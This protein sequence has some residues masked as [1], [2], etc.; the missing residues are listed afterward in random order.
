MNTPYSLND[1]GQQ[2]V[3]KGFRLFNRLDIGVA[4]TIASDGEW[5]RDGKVIRYG[6]NLRRRRGPFGFIL[7]W[8]HREHLFS[9]IVAWIGE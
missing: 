4:H 8:V 6:P 3:L 2:Q 5:A 1:R 7:S 9:L